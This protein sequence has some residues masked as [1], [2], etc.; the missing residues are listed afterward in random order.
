MKRSGI[1]IFLACAMVL[2]IAV[3]GIIKHR[4][5][6]GGEMPGSAVGK[7]DQI[8]KVYSKNDIRGFANKV[9][10]VEQTAI[11]RK[12][13]RD[14]DGRTVKYIVQM[15]TGKDME[16][17]LAIFMEM[18]PGW[19]MARVFL[20][21]W[22][23]SSPEACARWVVKNLPKGGDRSFI[24]QYVIRQWAGK[25]VLEAFAW[26]KTLSPE[27]GRDSALNALFEAWAGIDPEN[28]AKELLLIK[29]FDTCNLS[30]GMIAYYWARKDI[31]AATAWAWNLPKDSGYTS[32]LSSIARVLYETD[33]KRGSDWAK[34]L[35]AGYTNNP[36]LRR[37]ASFL[38]GSDSEKAVSVLAENMPG[39]FGTAPDI[40]MFVARWTKRDPEV[41]L[42]WARQLAD[43]QSREY[44]LYTI[45]QALTPVNRSAS[46]K[47]V[48]VVND[49]Q[50]ASGGQTADNKQPDK[51]SVPEILNQDL[52]VAIGLSE[53]I[54]DGPERDS[55]MHSV[56]LRWAEDDPAGAAAW[57]MQEMPEGLELNATLRT[58][59]WHWAENDSA[60]A[61][62]W[63]NELTDSGK[64]MDAQ[65]TIAMALARVNPLAAAGVI[66][67]IPCGETRNNVVSNVAFQWAHVDR[68]AV[69]AWAQ[70]LTV[71]QGREQALAAIQ[72]ALNN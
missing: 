11:L 48:E 64:H 32:A 44:A 57:V 62:S 29:D 43:S 55:V 33:K 1:W 65:A 68:N 20:S 38:T 9:S 25:N 30:K 18:K 27:Q 72:R 63:A 35:P 51:I 41:A 53:Q 66:E 2:F 4:W 49:G 71:E 13:L 39:G 28:A 46:A 47:V 56:A 50:A 23:D 58:I 54:P 7:K 17:A 42:A 12:A 24:T 34:S 40:Q 37:I 5:F 8:S 16:N 31:N 19:K 67:Q 21:A 26:V 3:F 61:L 10:D 70:K 14:G 60:G 22:A 69:T 36:A 59:I 45:T 52:S 15:L 6:C